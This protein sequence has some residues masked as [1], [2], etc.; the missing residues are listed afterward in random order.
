VVLGENLFPFQRLEV[1]CILGC[2]FILHLQCPAFK[3]LIPLSQLS[4]SFLKDSCDYTGPIRIIQN[5]LPVTGF[6]KVSF[7]PI[8]M[9]F[10][11]SGIRE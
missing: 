3:C 1:A 2:G 9:T 6:H 4:D 10:T 11:G 7:L 8:R 5:N